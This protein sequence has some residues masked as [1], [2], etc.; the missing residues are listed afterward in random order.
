[1]RNYFGKHSYFRRLFPKVK[2]Q[3]P[4]IDFYGRITFIQ[5]IICVFLIS[6]YTNLDARGTQNLESSSQ[7]SIY[8]VVMLFVQVFVMIL[9]RYISRTNTRVNLQ[10]ARNNR[11][12]ATDEVQSKMTL[13][14]SK[15]LSMHL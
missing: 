3:K 11:K 12:E 2:E 8:M 13:G 6:N 15:T 14:E 7:F 5:F 4:G 10:K 1:M 9:E